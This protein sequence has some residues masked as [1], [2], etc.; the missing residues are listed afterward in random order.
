[1]LKTLVT[2]TILCVEPISV[3]VLPEGT[4]F[5]PGTVLT[6]TA[7][8]NPSPTFQWIDLAD[9][10]T[11][12]GAVFTVPVYNEGGNNNHQVICRATNEIRSL[13]YTTY[14]DVIDITVI[15]K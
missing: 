14:S 3:T 4:N 9:N 8:G 13:T 12:N 11:T 6:C 7:S 2:E 5:Q 10:S 1:M 15:S